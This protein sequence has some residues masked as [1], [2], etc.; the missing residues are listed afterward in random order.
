MVFHWSLSDGLSPQFSGTLL[1]ILADVNESIVWMVSTRPLISMFCSP[2]INPS[3]TIPIAPITIGINATFMFHIFFQ[4]PSNLKEFI[5]LFPF[6][7]I[8]LHGQLGQPNP[9]FCK[10]SFFLLIIIRFGRLTE[11]KW[12]VC[13]SKSQRCLCVCHSP[14]QLTDCACTIYSYGQI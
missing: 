11:M 3:V 10:F 5:L 6:P 2:Y 1:S 13:M 14:G 7:S 12:S 8:L 4:F 9:Q